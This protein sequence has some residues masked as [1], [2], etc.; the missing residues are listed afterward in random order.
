MYASYLNVRSC[1]TQRLY[2]IFVS[3]YILFSK[4]YAIL[5]RVSNEGCEVGVLRSIQ[6]TVVKGLSA[7]WILKMLPIT[8]K[9]YY[10]EIWL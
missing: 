3:I 1:H 2:F 5:N 4:L 8:H 7:T 9:E 6:K 10:A